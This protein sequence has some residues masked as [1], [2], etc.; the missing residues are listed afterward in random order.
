I[1]LNQL[2]LFFAIASSIKDDLSLIQLSEHVL[3]V[4]PAV[5]PPS[6]EHFITL[7]CRIP[8]PTVQDCWNVFKDVLW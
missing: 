1:R 7:A 5:L 3:A 4:A 6:V 8:L 2:L